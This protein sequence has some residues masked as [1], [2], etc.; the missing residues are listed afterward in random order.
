M[1]DFLTFVTMNSGGNFSGDNGA[2]LR[3]RGLDPPTERQIHPQVGDDLLPQPVRPVLRR[4]DRLQVQ[5][6][7][8]QEHDRDDRNAPFFLT[9]S[10]ITIVSENRN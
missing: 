3:P 4:G 9:R 1:I 2:V 5:G 8:L 10:L 6:L 7:R